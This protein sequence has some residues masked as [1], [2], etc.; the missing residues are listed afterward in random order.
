[1]THDVRGD[2]DHVVNHDFGGILDGTD[3]NILDLGSDGERDLAG[4]GRVS[5]NQQRKAAKLTSTPAPIPV[6][7]ATAYLRFQARAE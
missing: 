2:F 7:K 3:K 1:M 5:M 4:D 6:T